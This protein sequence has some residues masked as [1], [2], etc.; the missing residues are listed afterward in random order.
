MNKG[1]LEEIF[2]GDE[3]LF[4]NLAVHEQPEAKFLAI[5]QIASD[6]E[7]EVVEEI[8]GEVLWYEWPFPSKY[9]LTNAHWTRADRA[10]LGTSE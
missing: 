5:G 8:S 3:L 4:P 9:C 7:T 2:G 1:K 10:P 6:N